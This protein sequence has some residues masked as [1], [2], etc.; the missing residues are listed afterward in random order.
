MAATAVKIAGVDRQFWEITAAADGDNTVDLVHGMSSAPEEVIIT[1][2]HAKATLAQ[3][4]AAVIDGTKVTITKAI[5]SS[6]GQAG[7]TLRVILRRS[8]HIGR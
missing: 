6:T 2:L 7:V 8:T 4:Y 5:T 3:W 1:P